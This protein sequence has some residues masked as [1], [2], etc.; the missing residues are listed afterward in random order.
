MPGCKQG[1]E[2]PP[3]RKFLLL[4]QR[5]HNATYVFATSI[6]GANVRKWALCNHNLVLVMLLYGVHTTCGCFGAVQHCL[7][8]GLC[9]VLTCSW[10]VANFV[11][12]ALTV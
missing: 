6:C 5:P 4:F 2:A 11:F 8:G 1:A 12:R 3:Y 9:I 10:C 7:N